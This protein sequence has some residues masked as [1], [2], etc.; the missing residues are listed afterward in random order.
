VPI[1][2]WKNQDEVAQ[3]AESKGTAPEKNN[4]GN[5]DQRQNTNRP[6]AKRKTSVV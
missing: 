6:L 5:D 2:K 4:R 3:K 1:R